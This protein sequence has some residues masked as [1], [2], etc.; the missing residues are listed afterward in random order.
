MLYSQCF[1]LTGFV[2]ATYIVKCSQPSEKSC[3]I[4]SSFSI[5]EVSRDYSKSKFLRGQ[6]FN[7]EIRVSRYGTHITA[8]SWTK[9]LND[10]PV[11][12][13]YWEVGS[14]AESMKKIAYSACW[15]VQRGYF[16]RMRRCG[17][18]GLTTSLLKTRS[19][20]L[21][22]EAVSNNA[23]AVNSGQLFKKMNGLCE[24]R[25]QMNEASATPTVSS[26]ETSSNVNLVEYFSTP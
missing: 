13:V 2:A 3:G 15:P 11:T 20:K 8:N 16:H 14:A 19:R 23:A 12:H 22:V 1:T 26:L 25:M 7:F 5:I 21:S 9:K 24:K 6:K 17:Q 4:M 10:E 18:K